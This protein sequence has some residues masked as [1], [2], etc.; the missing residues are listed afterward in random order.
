MIN[1]VPVNA[2]ASAAP[3]TSFPLNTIGSAMARECEEK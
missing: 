3:T 1:A 2:S